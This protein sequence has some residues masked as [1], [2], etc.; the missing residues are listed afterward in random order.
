MA[1]HPV[2]HAIVCPDT[3]IY[4]EGNP[5]KRMDSSESSKTWYDNV[6][7]LDKQIIEINEF[8]NM[9]LQMKDKLMKIGVKV[10]PRGILL[11]KFSKSSK[12]IS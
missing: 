4:S 6:G 1:V 5:V 2:R 3:V 9:K 8:I 10:P 7:G 12:F 11:H